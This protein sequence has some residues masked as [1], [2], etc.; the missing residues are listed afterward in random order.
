MVQTKVNHWSQ[1]FDFTK[2]ED[3]EL[4]YSLIQPSDFTL[5]DFSTVNPSLNIPS[6]NDFLFDLPVQFGGTLES[7]NQV[8][9]DSLMAFDIKTGAEEA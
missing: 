1:V 5:A 8:V 9:K 2:R 7:S 3:V 6:K 4:N